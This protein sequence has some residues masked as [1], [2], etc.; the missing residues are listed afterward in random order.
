[1]ILFILIASQFVSTLA[2]ACDTPI[3]ENSAL[4]ANLTTLLGSTSFC[5]S[6]QSIP[7]LNSNSYWLANPTSHNTIQFNLF[8][9]FGTKFVITG[10][11]LQQIVDNNSEC[12]DAFEQASLF[13]I[14]YRDVGTLRTL[15]T[16]NSPLGLFSLNGLTDGVGKIIKVRIS[17]LTTDYIQVS[18][19]SIRRPN[20][21]YE[22]STDLEIFC[23]ARY[24]QLLSPCGVIR[25][26]CYW[27]HH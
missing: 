18:I 22:L 19:A 20:S 25:V 26:C 4:N 13:Q 9:A 12:I 1:M 16:S 7:V 11:A 8:D 2:L 3:L 15:I 14:V 24:T 10:F 5:L 27:N 17:P 23:A 21:I 6:N